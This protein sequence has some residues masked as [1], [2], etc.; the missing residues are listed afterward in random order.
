MLIRKIHYGLQAFSHTRVAA[1]TAAAR[2]YKKESHAR[3]GRGR[4]K[5][6]KR[7]KRLSPADRAA[8]P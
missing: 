3:K 4:E 6:E 2:I 1:E 7:I 8:I 5:R